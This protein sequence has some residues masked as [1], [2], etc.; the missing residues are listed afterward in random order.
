MS[1]TF[2]VV[3]PKC[4]TT[5]MVTSGVSASGSG[6]CTCRNCHKNFRIYVDGNGNIIKVE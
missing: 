1:A 3:C 2:I 4:G 6:V 5:T